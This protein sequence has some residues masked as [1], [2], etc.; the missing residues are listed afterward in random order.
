MSS[1][2]SDINQEILNKVNSSNQSENVKSFIR[3]ALEF[4][5]NNITQNKPRFSEEYKRLVQHYKEDLGD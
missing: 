3:E 1:N 4:E 5:Y 2:K